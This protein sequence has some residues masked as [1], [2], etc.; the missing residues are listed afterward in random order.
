MWDFGDGN[1]GTG[2]KVLYSYATSG[3]Y[4]V[5]LAVA[6]VRCGFSDTVSLVISVSDTTTP[7]QIHLPDVGRCQDGTIDFFVQNGTSRYQ[8]SWDFGNGIQSAARNPTANYQ[9]TGLYQV[10]L[11]VTDTLCGE[12]YLD[13]ALID[14]DQLQSEIFIPNCFTPNGD[15][16][17]ELFIISGNQCGDGDVLEIYNRWGSR[18]YRTEKPYEEFWDGTFKG[19]QCTE[20]V[21]YYLL[22]TNNKVLKGHLSLI[23]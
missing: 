7:P 16:I 12:V 14:L 6:E 17:N 19:R 23:Y 9:D 13:T 1:F 10:I 11:R 2:S 22:F 18:L 4:R 8:Y 3:T 5:K 21:Y 15:G 20:S